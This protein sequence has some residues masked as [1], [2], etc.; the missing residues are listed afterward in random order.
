MY[1]GET[2]AINNFMYTFIAHTK[3]QVPF[4]K[5]FNDGMDH[6]NYTPDDAAIHWMITPQFRAGNQMDRS[7]TE[8]DQM[9]Y[10]HRG[11]AKYADIVRLFGW[12]TFT[13]FYNQENLDY[14]AGTYNSGGAD[15]RTLRFSKAAN[16]DLRPLI[17]FWG[18]LPV[19]EVALKVAVVDNAG[20][21]PSLQ[22]RC[23]LERYKTILPTDNEEFNAFYEKIYPSKPYKSSDNP[24]YGI[25][26]FHTQ[27]STYSAADGTSGIARIDALLQLYFPLEMRQQSC[28]GVKTGEDENEVIVPTSWSWMPN[29]GMIGVGGDGVVTQVDG[30]STPERTPAETPETPEPEQGSSPAPGSDQSGGSGSSA[31]NG[32][33]GAGENKGSNTVN[34]TAPS[35]SGTKGGGG[36]IDAGLYVGL[37][38]L[39]FVL[40]V[41][42]PISAAYWYFIVKKK[43]KDGG[44]GETS[45]SKPAVATTVIDVEMSDQIQKTG[46]E[47][48]LPK[49]PQNQRQQLDQFN[50]IRV[51]NGAKNVGGHHHN[52]HH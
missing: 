24:L 30:T 7:N 46:T 47:P 45:S 18:A 22:V 4:N 51:K 41:A 35:L 48:S 23:L 38:V 32:G 11:Y 12:E 15:G 36:S 33:T 49:R 1:P 21:L 20:L 5:A 16:V 39:F 13:S 17:H 25:G 28:V 8:H 43:N 37:F 19:N 44:G 40:F 50:N 14:N 52:H 6:S 42:A 31:K 29:D 10:Q 9:R 26:W 3:F 34:G 27:S 2:E